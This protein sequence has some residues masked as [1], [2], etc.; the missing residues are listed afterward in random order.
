MVV[1]LVLG[2]GAGLLFGPDVAFFFVVGLIL[3]LGVTFVYLMAN[4]AVFRF[5]RRE[6]RTEFNWLLH[7]VFPLV[8]SIVLL[9]AVYASFFPDLPA[10]PF[11][12][13][14]IV[15]GVWLLIGIAILWWMRSRG[16]ED[17][18]LNAGKAVGE[19]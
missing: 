17:W 3:V 12:Y 2:V 10:E 11:R 6:K 7:F 19:A 9:Y 1:S 16:R 15:D 8:S 18:L 13:A 4:V 5:Y 14:P